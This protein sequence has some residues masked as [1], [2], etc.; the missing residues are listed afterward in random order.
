VTD[1]PTPA[2]EQKPV[3]DKAAETGGQNARGAEKFWSLKALTAGRLSYPNVGTGLSL[4]GGLV[5]GAAA[6][7]MVT[8]GISLPEFN[9]PVP[10]VGSSASSSGEEVYA[11]FEL[12]LRRFEIAAG[13]SASIR[14]LKATLDDP[15]LPEDSSIRSQAG[16]RI[17]ELKRDLEKDRAAAEQAFAEIVTARARSARTYTETFDRAV[18]QATET[19]SYETL[20][21]LTTLNNLAENQVSAKDADL[22]EFRAF[23]ESRFE[24]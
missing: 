13:T 4:V 15:E 22:T 3:P 19:A 18:A 8:G 5:F 12:V 17:E 2:S 9:L 1:A 16:D 24:Q 7:T 20:E 6:Y 14:D 11:R 21:I 10:N 23:W